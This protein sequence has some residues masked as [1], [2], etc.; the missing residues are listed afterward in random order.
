MS[1]PHLLNEYEDEIICDLAETY[2][3]L[4]YR[5]VSPRVLIKLIVGLR[6]DS[7]LVFKVTGRNYSI[8]QLLQAYTVDRLS[9]L[10]WQKTKDGAKGKN[11]PKLLSDVMLKVKEETDIQAYDSAAEFERHRKEILERQQ[12]G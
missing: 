11:K 10:C 8:S 4:D 2:G 6:E 7:R 3:V 5:K 9:V 12:H 1:L